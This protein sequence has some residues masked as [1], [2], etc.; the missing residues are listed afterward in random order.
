[1]RLITNFNSR[2]MKCNCITYSVVLCLIS[3]A[4]SLFEAMIQ[5]A[6]HKCWKNNNLFGQFVWN[7]QFVWKDFNLAK[8]PHRSDFC[9]ILSI[10]DWVYSIHGFH[11][12][13]WAGYTLCD[14]WPTK[15]KDNHHATLGLG[16]KTV[17]L[18]QTVTQVHGWPTV[19][20]KTICDKNLHSSSLTSVHARRRLR[21]SLHRATRSQ[22]TSCQ[23]QVY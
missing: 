22:Q 5:A 11:K 20:P 23:T 4:N 3:G 9:F 15:M 21:F 10:F 13:F 16:S 8:E 1:M 12:S 7:W 14:F 2:G 17:A 18:R 19:H 6:F